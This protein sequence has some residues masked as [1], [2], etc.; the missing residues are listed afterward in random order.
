MGNSDAKSVYLYFKQE[1]GAPSVT[2]TTFTAGS[3]MLSAGAGLGVGAL[4]SGLAVSAAGKKKRKA[5][6]AAEEA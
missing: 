3:L 1:E 4:V 5:D 2:G 6:E